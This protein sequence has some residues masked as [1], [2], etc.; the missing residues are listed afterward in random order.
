MRHSRNPWRDEEGRKLARLYVEVP[1]EHRRA[2]QPV[3]AGG[4]AKH[5]RGSRGR[6]RR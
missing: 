4:A 1:A 3:P 6:K 2:A 5:G